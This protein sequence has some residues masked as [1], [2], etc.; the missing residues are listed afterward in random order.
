MADRVQSGEIQSNEEHRASGTGFDLPADDPRRLENRQG[1]REFAE[2]SA[3]PMSHEMNAAELGPAADGTTGVATP[4]AH[5]VGAG[6]VVVSSVAEDSV[7]YNTTGL[8]G[9]GSGPAGVGPIEG[10]ASGAPVTAPQVEITDVGAVDMSVAGP[11]FLAGQEDGTMG[12]RVENE[13][14]EPL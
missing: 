10:S 1:V 4:Q 5:D 9:T 12:A 8:L 2:S 13:N 6:G 7:S 11:D 14:G 3:E